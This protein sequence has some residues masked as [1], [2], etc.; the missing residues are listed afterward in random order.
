MSSNRRPA[1]LP[2]APPIVVRLVGANV[3]ALLVVAAELVEA[4]EQGAAV[5]ESAARLEQ[6][7]LRAG[8]RDG[9]GRPQ[10]EAKAG[11][12]VHWSPFPSCDYGLDEARDGRHLPYPHRDD[13]RIAR[14]SQSFEQGFRPVALDPPHGDVALDQMDAAAIGGGV[15]LPAGRLPT[16]AQP[17]TGAAV[18]TV[19]MMSGR[20]KSVGM[21]M[22]LSERS[23][24][25]LKLST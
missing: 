14:R 10:F 24:P 19:E 4:V 13:A 1:D 8:R 17:S 18:Y 20:S 15:Q 11:V 3:V 21:A 2:H 9:T 22:S 25:F 12:S 5:P 16:R 23:V 7:A 6:E